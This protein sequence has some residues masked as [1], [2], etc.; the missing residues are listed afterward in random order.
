M[1]QEPT[2]RQLYYDWLQKVGG[3]P[4]V[5]SD[6]LLWDVQRALLPYCQATDISANETEATIRNLRVHLRNALIAYVGAMPKVDPLASNEKQVTAVL[7]HVL[8]GDPHRAGDPERAL[9]LDRQEMREAIVTLFAH[10]S[11]SATWMQNIAPLLLDGVKVGMRGAD[12]LGPDGKAVTAMKTIEQGTAG[13]HV[14]APSTGFGVDRVLD[15]TVSVGA[16]SVA[17][18]LA[19]STEAGAAAQGPTSPLGVIWAQVREFVDKISGGIAAFLA[20]LFN[21]YKSGVVAYLKGYVTDLQKLLTTTVEI[22]VRQVLPSFTM[23]YVSI[24]QLKDQ[25][26]HLLK[27]AV[28]PILEFFQYRHI[29]FAAGV[30][31]DVIDGMRL[32]Q[33]FMGADSVFQVTQTLAVFATAT[34]ATPNAGLILKSLMSI[35]QN[36]AKMCLRFWEYSMLRNVCNEARAVALSML[37]SETRIVNAA[38][39]PDDKWFNAWFGPYARLVPSVAAIVLSSGIAGAKHVWLEFGRLL[40]ANPDE[41]AKGGNYLASL[42]TQGRRYLAQ[43]GL[44]VTGGEGMALYLTAGKVLGP[45]PEI[46]QKAKTSW[47]NTLTDALTGVGAVGRGPY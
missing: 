39:A 19:A 14:T 34:V 22:I 32:G 23:G 36:L 9:M 35:G 13:L 43:S 44:V 18:E 16:K 2:G 7:S 28:N 12:F 17:Q 4:A 46:A 5:M 3:M 20:R 30:A 42:A 11:V 24:V 29:R 27:T 1:N 47:R 31:S 10:A 25:L 26:P 37:G 45:D 41:F 38:G 40:G 15:A 33:I 8:F 6:P 21:T